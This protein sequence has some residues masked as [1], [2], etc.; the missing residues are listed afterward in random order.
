MLAAVGASIGR[1]GKLTRA[2]VPF[3]DS[4]VRMSLPP[5]SSASRRAMGNPKPL[6]LGSAA[7]FAGWVRS[8]N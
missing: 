1:A 7:A 4:L 5:W 6:T 2:V 3:P 8:A